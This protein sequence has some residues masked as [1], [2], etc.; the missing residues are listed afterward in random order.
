MTTAL[1][2]SGLAAAM[3]SSEG[4]RRAVFLD[5]D[6]V[7]NQAIVR[8]GKPY[9]ATCVDEVRILPGVLEALAALEAAGFVLIVVTNQPDVARGRLSRDEVEAIHRYMQTQLPIHDWRT[10]YH[11]DRDGC[12]CRKPACGMLVTAALDHGIDL[13]YSVMV[14]DRWRDIAAGRAAGCRTIFIDH[15]YN[16]RQPDQWDVRARDLADAARHILGGE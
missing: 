7:L 8:D 2:S 1:E 15:R 10:C 13:R 3:S 14:G 16:E 9:P 4:R 5:R 11:D 6:G 12:E